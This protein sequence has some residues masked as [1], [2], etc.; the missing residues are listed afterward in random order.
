MERG[1]YICGAVI[2]SAHKLKIPTLLHESNSFPGKA[3]KML[4]QKTDVIMVS[5]KDAMYR[6]PK[7]KKVVLTGTPT[8]RLEKP[9][10]LTEKI[11]L[12][13][14]YKLNPAKP[15]VLIFGGSQGAKI[16]NDTIIEL[17][18][19]K[20]NKNYQILLAARAETI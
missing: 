11:A 14:K 17:A 12:K 6:I 2:T 18:K 19:M 20:L 15:V 9:L 8:R 4:S 1:G 16:I 10:N 7:A 3:V 13:E 5:F